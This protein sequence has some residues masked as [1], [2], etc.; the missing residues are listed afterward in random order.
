[1][2]G[3]DFVAGLLRS[4]FHGLLSNGMMLI[5]V[6][7]RRTGRRYTTPVEYYRDGDSLWVLT[8]RERTWWR[9]LKS[10]APVELLVKGKPVPGMAETVL[11]EK[12]VEDRMCEY[13]RHMPR[14]A[15]PLGIRMENGSPRGEDIVRTAQARLFVRIRV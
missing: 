9:N 1:V 3:N 14:A 15:K 7:G 10:G 13:L 2:S 12:A 5:T 6:T 11:E 4:P 8:S